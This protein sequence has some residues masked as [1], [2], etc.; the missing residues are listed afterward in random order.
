MTTVDKALELGKKLLQDV[1][2][3]PP[4]FKGCAHEGCEKRHCAKGYCDS[5][6]A[7]T[8]SKGFTTDIK[9][10]Y[11]G[12]GC[13]VDGCVRKH[14]SHGLCGAHYSE[15]LRSESGPCT[16][17][18]C[19]DLQF[20]RSSGLCSRHWYQQRHG[21]ELMPLENAPCRFDGCPKVA[22]QKG[23]HRGWCNGHKTQ[24]K[25]GRELKP[26][27][28]REKVAGTW[29]INSQG[30]VITKIPGT[31]KVLLQHRVVME[32]HLG[33]TLLPWENVHHKNGNRQDN[34]V[35]NLELWSKSQ[36]SGQRV[37]DKTSWAIEW[38]KTY[39]PDAL[40]GDLLE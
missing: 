26:L 29:R 20:I 21:L 13:T 11:R 4:R 24:I 38:L 14:K 3:A 9:P 12:E 22:L 7:Q 34:R 8:R 40:R 30:Y 15:K 35:E 18:G 17:E 36:P 10:R 33:R 28:H 31:H 37:E 32:Q 25:E 39:Q 6:Y 23:P 16:F 2:M 27:S 19:T 1:P 5:H